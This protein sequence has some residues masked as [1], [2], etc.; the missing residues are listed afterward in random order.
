MSRL[1]RLWL[2]LFELSVIVGGC[3]AA[4]IAGVA[5]NWAGNTTPVFIESPD[6]T[7]DYVVNSKL[8]AGSWLITRRF[9]KRTDDCA[10]SSGIWL[11]D[12]RGVVLYHID[13]YT[14]YAPA[15]DTFAVVTNGFYVQPGVPPGHY[16]IRVYVNCQHNPL[17]EIN[18]RLRDL[19]LE[20]LP[21]DVPIPVT[22]PG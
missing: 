10:V 1:A 2:V 20:I 6:A 4:F 12:N 11:V 3:S 21:P 22:P 17:S 19:P 9:L 8:H 16:K 15:R 18:L 14:S 13:D 5:L 7:T